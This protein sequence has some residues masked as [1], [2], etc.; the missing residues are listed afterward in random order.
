[1]KLDIICIAEMIVYAELKNIAVEG[2]MLCC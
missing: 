2:S 1:M